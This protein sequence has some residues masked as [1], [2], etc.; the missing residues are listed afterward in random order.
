ML[1][2]VPDTILNSFLTLY[3]LDRGC[4]Y[5]EIGILWSIY[6]GSCALVD[7]PTGGLADKFGRRKIYAFG[8]FVTA[9]SYIILCVS[10][11]FILFVVSYLVKGI[12][13]SQMT[14]ALTSWLA[15]DGN[16][17]VY[18]NSIK[19]SRLFLSIMNVIIPIL[20]V[21]IKMDRM[22]SVILFCGV[23]YIILSMIVI[24]LLKENYGSS[25]NLKHIYKN[26]FLVF[27]ENK[28]MIEL[29][30]FNIFSYTLY[31]TFMFIWQ[32]IAES[33]VEFVNIMPLVFA[34]FTFFNG[35]GANVIGKIVKKTFKQYIVIILLFIFAFVSF[36]IALN[37]ENWCFLILSM[38]LFGFANGSFFIVNSVKLNNVAQPEYKSSLFSLMSSITTGVT[39][40]IQII[41]GYII[42]CFGIKTLIDITIIISIL[43]LTEKIFGELI[44]NKKV[45]HDV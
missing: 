42:D 36:Y 22:D 7:Y 25:R 8:L 30:F 3:L 5:S 26:S 33:I 32:P 17:K 10:N 38:S 11:A 45:K 24:L 18:E 39:F 31:T 19:K 43:F 20:C 13:T 35:V 16:E 23:F 27:F 29:L 1:A 21:I 37:G 44:L 14:G 6:L 2:S 9:I 34:C 41:F 15:C 12:G 40:V 4:S 28:K